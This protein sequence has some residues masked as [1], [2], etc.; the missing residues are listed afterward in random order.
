LKKNL[1]NS[2]FLR[3]STTLVVG[4]FIS[5]LL[6]FL[7]LPFIAK[8]YSPDQIGLHASL[9]SISLVL[10]IFFTLQYHHAI[11]IP[12]NDR[13]VDGL[14]RL[15]IYISIIFLFISIPIF[16]LMKEN[17]DE[18]SFIKKLDGI[19]LWAPFFAFLLALNQ[20]FINWFSK[21]RRFQII[22]SNNI[23]ISFFNNTVGV[24]LGTMSFGVLGLVIANLLANTFS[25]IKYLI[26]FLIT[27]KS[28]NSFNEIKNL[29]KKYSKFPKITLYHSL[30]SSLSS[31]LPILIIISYFN[32]SI[33]GLY[34]LASRLTK[35]PFTLIN[36]SL[37]NVF[38]EEFSR[39]EN[40]YKYFRKR[41][42]QLFAISFPLFII[43]ML[44]V[45]FLVNIFL[46]SRYSEISSMVLFLLPLFYLKL[47]SIFNVSGLFFFQKNVFL[48]QVEVFLFFLNILA[49][50]VSIVFENFYLFLLLNLI[51]FLFVVLLRF[52]IFIKLLKKSNHAYK[53]KNKSTLK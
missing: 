27:N 48:F 38:F 14:A 33:T 24:L 4:T 12:K 10:S 16:F 5:Q 11:L 18:I 51:F 25:S 32:P 50:Y 7:F 13:N 34:F 52:K 17:L 21:K 40:K 23:L 28:T 22:S 8:L 46:D 47:L 26:H 37:Y 3:N 15:S 49:L 43:S 19:I 20:I 41:F 30:F 53:N 42:I 45:P 29:S 6:T 9:L 31:E 39:V 1:I 36:S 2:K 35:V 44:I